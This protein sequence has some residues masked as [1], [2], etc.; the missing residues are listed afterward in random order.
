[1]SG[2]F[3]QIAFGHCEFGQ[4]KSDIEPR[5]YTSDPGDNETD[6]SIYQTIISFSVYGF[7]S[8]TQED[9]FLH[10]EVSEDGGSSFSDAYVNGS[11][12]SPYN[13]GESGIDAHQA[14]SEEFGVV[15]EKT[16]PWTDEKQIV[17]RVTSQDEY[18][19]ES[20]KETPQTWP[21]IR[22]HR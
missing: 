6:V 19:S 3:G 15:I 18:G 11:F 5:Y 17:V 8:R 1:M 21:E 16:T 10:I 7:S 20:T 2:G 22:V 4:S 13:G 9:D 12:V 14:Y